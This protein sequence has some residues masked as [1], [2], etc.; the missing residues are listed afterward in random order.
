MKLN[1]L[2]FLL[3]VL[4][5]TGNSGLLSQVQQ[6][7]NDLLVS[8]DWLE[9]NRTDSLL[10]ILHYG[11]KTE[12]E[13]EHI[14]GA[15]YISIWDILVE[16]EQGLRQ[17]F[18]DEQALEQVFRSWGLNNNSKIIICYQN[19]DA[20]RWASRLF[21][22]LDYAG[23][24]NQVA[25][26]DGGLEAW[27]EEGRPVTQSETAFKE[28]TIDITIKDEVR[29]SKEEVLAML[30]REGV[31]MVDARPEGRYYGTSEDDDSPRPGHIEGAVNI[32]ILHLFSE[33]TPYMFKTKND[34]RKLFEEQKIS[35]ESL[36]ITYCGTGI[37][38][39]VDYFAARLLGYRVRL[40]DGSFQEWSRD[41]SLPVS[42]TATRPGSE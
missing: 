21:L 12:F 39:S 36:V 35:P 28:G 18:P 26:L 38:A 24:G 5:S 11:M 27:K 42:K 14:P 17:E 8:T 40:Y 23:L 2:L 13:K 15:R 29:I 4:I 34:L 6:R 20:I 22:T 19:R 3:S 37:L 7:F 32:P 30:H 25:M 33:D 1:R 10:V 16:D 31:V 9:E 41:E